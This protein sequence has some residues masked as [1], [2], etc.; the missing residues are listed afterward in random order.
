MLFLIHRRLGPATRVM[1]ALKLARP[2][3]LLIAA[4]GPHDD[5]R[6]ADV[7]EQMLNKIDWPCQVATRFLD[8]QMG[9]RNAV[10]SALDWAFG[11]HE[12]LIILEDDCVPHACFFAFCSAMLDRY[13]NES[14]VMQICGSNLTGMRPAEQSYFF[15]RFGPIWG[16]ASWR[17]AWQAYDVEMKEWS[18]LR[19]STRLHQLCPEPFEAGWRHEVLE[20]VYR[21][22]VDTWDY[23]WA[24]AKLRSGGLN[25]VPAVN[26]VSNIGFGEDATHTTNADDPRAEMEIHELASP[27]RHADKIIAWQEADRAYLTQVV[28]LPESIWSAKGIRRS[29]RSLFKL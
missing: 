7:R 23:Q 8:E 19:N 13:K 1:S 27:L 14:E 22:E 20:A 4:D 5:A 16:W 26:L 28:G 18:T 15:S 29:L 24:F 25:I 21:G 6:C 17:R 12:Q 9:C 2:E 10:S 11:L 3:V